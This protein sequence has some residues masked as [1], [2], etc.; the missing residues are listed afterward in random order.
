MEVDYIIVGTGIAGATLALELHAR[1]K[2][3]AIW[4]LPD[5]A[6]SS[7]NAAGIINPIVPKRVTKT[8]MC[9]VVFPGIE[10]YYQNWEKILKG[11][12]YFPYSMYQIHGSARDSNEWASKYESLAPYLEEAKIELPT[13]LE[14][15]FGF[16]KIN[17]AGRLN[18]PAFCDA[19]IDFLNSNHTVF[20]QTFQYNLLTRNAAGKWQYFDTIA[21]SVIF[22]EGI[23]ALQNP[24]FNNLPFIPSGGDILT[25]K[26]PALSGI[27]QMLK[28]QSWLVPADDETFL[29]GSTFH[30][31][32]DSIIPEKSDE[33]ALVT[34]LKKWIKSDI[35]VINHKR[36]LR[37]TVKDRRPF[38][39]EHKI[40]KGL[41]IF[42]GLG[43]KGSSLVTWLA[44]LMADYLTKNTAL[45]DEINIQKIKPSF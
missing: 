21:T 9:D 6:A 44:P 45:P 2:K 36:A 16:S 29:A 38:L 12:Y 24:W 3:L 42:N 34:G 43:T 31:N 33:D 27:Q 41:H 37:P 20:H 13:Y 17:F 30:Q 18:V 35:E 23:K 5:E 11:K 14:T 7:R 32:N 39:G 22:C 25:L 15:P 1:G 8:W 40:E 10:T 4:N 26:I 28:Q 19:T